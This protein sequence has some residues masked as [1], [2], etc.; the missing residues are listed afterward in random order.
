MKFLK[1]RNKHIISVVAIVVAIT[2]AS[3]NIML[4]A[5]NGSA[6]AVTNEITTVVASENTTKDELILQVENLISKAEN[7]GIV[8][9][10]EAESKE[11]NSL[12]EEELMDI[13]ALLNYA[14][15]NHSKAKEN[16]SKPK[17]NNNKIKSENTLESSAIQQV[18]GG[19]T[20]YDV[21]HGSYETP[22]TS[23][24]P[25]NGLTKSITTGVVVYARWANKCVANIYDDNV[26]ESFYKASQYTATRGTSINLGTI[27]SFIQKSI[28]V[29]RAT[30]TSF[31]VVGT[32]VYTINLYGVVIEYLVPF[33]R[34]FSIYDGTFQYTS[35]TAPF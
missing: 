34:T 16:E 17:N 29:E 27:K 32:G 10:K 23:T 24:V 30:D 20:T 26:V 25:Y 7:I 18:V 35:N 31:M 22:V 28:G 3:S 33:S 9:T 1:G 4:A 15:E 2:L 6:T 19:A 13:I 12:S 8:I 11:F 21:R 5:T 14:I